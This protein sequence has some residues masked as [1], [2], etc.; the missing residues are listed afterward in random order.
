MYTTAVSDGLLEA[1]LRC[2]RNFCKFEEN[3]NPQL[4]VF[5]QI[6]LET[7]I[8]IMLSIVFPQSRHEI[9]VK[10]LFHTNTPVFRFSPADRAGLKTGDYLI[11]VNALNVSTASHDDVVSLIGSSTGLLTLQIAENYNDSDSSDDDYH[12]KPKS[13]YPNRARLRGQPRERDGG[14]PGKNAGGR[15][16][17]PSR[18]TGQLRSR[19]L[20]PTVE[21]TLP[22]EIAVFGPPEPR[23]RSANRADARDRIQ[24]NENLDPL[25][26][27][28][29]PRK[30]KTV[31]SGQ[32]HSGSG[33]GLHHMAR[34][35]QHQSKQASVT[36]DLRMGR[37]NQ[38]ARRANPN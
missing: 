6:P 28:V 22:R 8:D 10:D 9:L 14:R 32:Q 3:I 26:V 25:S 11:S 20:S 29:Y 36:R 38:G 30:Q 15:Y 16:P 5:G 2:G 13:K 34:L 31:G 12:N 1:F 17:M 21:N 4:E 23:S 7:G 19:A 37:T 18:S 24:G 33:D 35:T 27:A